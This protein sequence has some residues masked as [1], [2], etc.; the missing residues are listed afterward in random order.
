MKIINKDLITIVINGILIYLIVYLTAS[1]ILIAGHFGK[2]I[3]R[4]FVKTLN[5]KLKLLKI[6]KEIKVKGIKES[7]LQRDLILS[8]ILIICFFALIVGL[9]LLL[10]YDKIKAI[11]IELKP[12][13]ITNLILLIVFNA[14]VFI[15][16]AFF[17]SKKIMFDFYGK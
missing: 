5:E 6:K 3:D 14:P 12:E 16:I 7:I 13:L 11:L 15:Y 10:N 17:A 4:S 9:L 1:T 2:K 8:I